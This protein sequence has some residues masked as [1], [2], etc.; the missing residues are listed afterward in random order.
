MQYNLFPQKK[1]A[2]TMLC[3]MSGCA[4]CFISNN[5]NGQTAADGQLTGP[6][7]GSLL[8][9]LEH[10]KLLDRIPAA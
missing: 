8:Y 6:G 9:S 4:Y 5:T 1:A 10:T 2:K 3:K 7:H